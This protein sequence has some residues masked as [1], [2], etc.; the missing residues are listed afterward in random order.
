MAATELIY[1]VPSNEEIGRAAYGAVKFKVPGYWSNESITI[2]VSR[3]WGAENSVDAWRIEVSHS[4]GGRDT[5]EIESDAD[6][7]EQFALALLKAVE[8]ARE[9]RTQIPAI[10][11]AYLQQCEDWKREQALEDAEREQ[12]IEA[13]PAY[14]EHA[15]KALLEQMIKDAKSGKRFKATLKGRGKSAYKT[16]LMVYMLAHNG[17]VMTTLAGQRRSKADIIAKLTQSSAAN[18]TVEELN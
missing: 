2:R 18:S 6:A 5:N 13:D 9:L 10:H 3:Y 4:S 17:F 16:E 15:A 1:T 11:A 12:A 7:E 8:V 14:T